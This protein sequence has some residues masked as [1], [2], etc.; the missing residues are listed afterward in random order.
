[1]ARRVVALFIFGLMPAIGFPVGPAR[2]DTHLAPDD[3]PDPKQAGP[4][5][6]PTESDL[7]RLQSC[8][9]KLKWEVIR[10][11]GHPKAVR[12]DKGG[13]EIWDYPWTAC[14]SVSFKRGICVSTSYTGGY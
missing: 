7:A 6:C 8:E 10:A 9:G 3:N 11:L 4:A 2:T 1:M 13:T 5:L 14:C 12:W